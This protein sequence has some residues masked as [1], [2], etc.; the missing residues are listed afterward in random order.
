MNCVNCG[1]QIADEAVFCRYCG[2]RQEEYNA[3]ELD[4]GLEEFQNKLDQIVEA[5][6]TGQ[7]ARGVAIAETLAEAYPDSVPAW[8]MVG[9]VNAEWGDHDRAMFGFDK[10]LRLD[11]QNPD[12]LGGMGM[13]LFEKGEYRKALQYLDKALAIQRDDEL[14]YTAVA[15][16]ANI[17]SIDAAIRRC[18]QYVEVAEDR[19]FLENKLG[20]CYV[21]KAFSYF[22]PANDGNS[23]L[24]SKDAVSNAK[25]Y[26]AKALPLMTREDLT[27]GDVKDAKEMLESC[28]ISENRIFQGHLC[29]A[30]VLWLI[31][32]VI[33]TSFL[34]FPGILFIIYG[35][36][37]IP[38]S[39][40]PQWRVNWAQC[41]PGVRYRL[42][43]AIIDLF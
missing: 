6:E 26:A 41:Y 12:A 3:V 4:V 23:Y 7:L 18:A 30:A 8:L 27:A 24:M 16:V 10:V 9:F 13:S 22:T 32:G 43:N 40:V 35:V 36:I 11:P 5:M 33:V 19:E 28:K 37:G 25:T 20:Q 2:S 34:P 29:R 21:S 42:H 31:L 14:M 39:R 15:A 1:K 38:A 17:D